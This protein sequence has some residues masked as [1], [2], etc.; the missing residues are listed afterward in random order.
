MI[1][2]VKSQRYSKLVFTAVTVKIDVMSW[3]YQRLTMAGIVSTKT[4]GSCVSLPLSR[5]E[6]SITFQL[7][8]I[9]FNNCNIHDVDG[10][11]SQVTLVVGCVKS[12]AP[13]SI[14]SR[15]FR[16]PRIQIQLIK[17]QEWRSLAYNEEFRIRPLR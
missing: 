11:A 15:G 10:Q 7:N 8:S 13:M 6:D 17:P 3:G 4:M 5:V 12:L 1:L 9:T 16:L 14:N 2:Q